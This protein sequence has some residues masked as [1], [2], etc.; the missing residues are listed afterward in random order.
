MFDHF[1]RS[2][3]GEPGEKLVVCNA[4]LDRQAGTNVPAL[5]LLCNLCGEPEEVLD[6]DT[7]C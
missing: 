6:V 2:N 4:E 5:S 7:A 1:V 3:L